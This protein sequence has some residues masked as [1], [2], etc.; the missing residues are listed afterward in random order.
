MRGSE[1]HMAA[2]H[3]RDG[4]GAVG[5]LTT[6]LGALPDEYR[7]DKTWYRAPGTHD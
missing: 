5:H 2:L 6:G 4:Q 7:R 1:P 3:L